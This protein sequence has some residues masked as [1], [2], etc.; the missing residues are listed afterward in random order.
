MKHRLMR[1]ITPFV[2]MA[3]I[4][5]LAYGQTSTSSLTGTVTDP[6]GAVIPGAEISAKNN[7]NGTVYTAV[8]S[9]KIIRCSGGRSASF[10]SRGKCSITSRKASN[11]KTSERGLVPSRSTMS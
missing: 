5:T 7:D 4:A 10:G 2:C 3:M 1:V 6:S 9:D 11:W 8:S